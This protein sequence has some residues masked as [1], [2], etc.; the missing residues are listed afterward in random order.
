MTATTTKITEQFQEI[1]TTIATDATITMKLFEDVVKTAEEQNDET[2]MV[3]VPVHVAKAIMA[4]SR[5]TVALLLALKLVE[6]DDMF[7]NVHRVLGADETPQVDVPPT[8][9]HEP[10]TQYKH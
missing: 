5:K 7:A 10:S 4:N 6:L 1:A 8:F 9:I 2:L 3:A